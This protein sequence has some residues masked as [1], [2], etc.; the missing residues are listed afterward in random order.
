MTSTPKQDRDMPPAAPRS[1]RYEPAT[2]ARTTVAFWSI[3]IGIAAAVVCA[4]IVIDILLVAFAALLIAIFL[5]S[6]GDLV[7]RYTPLNGFWSVIVVILVLL[8]MSVG[9]G[10]I[11]FPRI[12]D[13]LE[14][15]QTSLPQAMES[16][17]QTLDRYRIGHWV[18]EHL[19][20]LNELRIGRIN[21]V[22]GVAGLISNATWAVGMM[23]VACIVGLYI[24]LKPEAYREGAIA[25]VPP[26]RRRRAE[27]V[28]ARVGRALQWWLLG[29]CLSMLIVGLLTGLGLWLLGIDLALTLAIIA[30]VLAF[31]PN[32]GP[33]M[34]AIPAVLL[35]IMVSPM[36]GVWV[37]V[38]Y[39]GIQT[40]ESYILTPLI[41][42][43]TISL[44]PGL[45][46]TMQLVMG[47]LL[48]GVGLVLA[49]PLTAAALVLVK[50]LY[51]EPNEQGL[52]RLR[53][54][55]S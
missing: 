37:A 9:V 1:R 21:W 46:I 42:K 47:V 17:K 48:G 34:A 51:V 50:E 24:A 28:F 20:T 54:G 5:R 2:E 49:T 25:L 35:G 12:D 11:V 22:G 14:Q 40:V 29:K 23:I 44:P 30:T 7:G 16:L 3:G 13:Q 31:I 53:R 55:D 15:M 45:T 39:I 4:V 38:L 8:G 32:F 41:H 18:M 52:D 43:R 19:P 26:Q 6:L 10:L 33:I 36:M 27:T